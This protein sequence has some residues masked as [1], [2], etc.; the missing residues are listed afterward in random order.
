MLSREF[1]FISEF[2]LHKH[3]PIISPFTDNPSGR[4]WRL[5]MLIWTWGS[6]Y[7]AAGSSV[8]F[9]GSGSGSTTSGQTTSTSPT[10][11]RP[12]ESLGRRNYQFLFCFLSSNNNYQAGPH[13]PGHSGP[14]QTGIWSGARDGTSEKPIFEVETRDFP[15]WIFHYKPSVITFQG[16]Q[17]RYLLHSS[18]QQQTEA[19][20]VQH[21]QRP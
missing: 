7:T 15:N 1:I 8:G 13:H 18:D 5:R 10:T 16:E 2:C 19:P 11:W 4:W 9:S 14:S 3:S 6:A 17:H 20:L 21:S 12:G